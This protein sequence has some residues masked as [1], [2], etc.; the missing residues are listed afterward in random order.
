MFM[1][2]L[3]LNDPE[4]SQD[5]LDAWD[6]AGAP[7]V[8]ILPSTGLGRVRA[9][10]GLKDDMPLL[11]SLEDFFVDEESLHRTIIAILRDQ[12]MVDRIV[13]ATQSILG[14][15]NQPNTGILTVLPVLEAYG[16][17]RYDE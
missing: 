12:P 17:D 11:P 7:G 4:K 10:T 16:L 2:M 5:L 14:D 13:K 15:L 3:I 6:Q 8:T 1:V 9:K